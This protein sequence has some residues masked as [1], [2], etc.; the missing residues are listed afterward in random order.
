LDDD[1][2]EV[3]DERDDF[4]VPKEWY[5]SI[6]LKIGVGVVVAIAFYVIFQGWGDSLKVG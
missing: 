1:W 3:P 4:E 6:W 5:D 2:A